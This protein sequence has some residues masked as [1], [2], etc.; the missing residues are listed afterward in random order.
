MKLFVLPADTVGVATEAG[1]ALIH[2]GFARLKIDRI[3]NGIS[4]LNVRSR[5]LMQRLGFTF[6]DN[7]NPDDLIGMLERH[8][9][10]PS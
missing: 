6:L 10:A 7:G 9:P 1:R 8:R 3:N 2:N 4:P 5:N